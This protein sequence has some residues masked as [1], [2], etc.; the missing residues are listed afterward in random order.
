MLW[1]QVTV[2]SLRADVVGADRVCIARD[3]AAKQKRLGWPLL[4]SAVPVRHQETGEAEVQASLFWCH[5]RNPFSCMV[6]H[7]SPA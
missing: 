3:V 1:H 2:L 7:P 4:S 5:C 6:R